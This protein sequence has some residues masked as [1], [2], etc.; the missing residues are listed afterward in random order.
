M[1]LPGFAG[2]PWVRVHQ[3]STAPCRSA[4]SIERAD[5]RRGVCLGMYVAVARINVVVRR[6]RGPRGS[7]T[8]RAATGP[9]SGT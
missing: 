2:E 3:W 6:A 8:S 7:T 4:T 9:S 1:A 5:A